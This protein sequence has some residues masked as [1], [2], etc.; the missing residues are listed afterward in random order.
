MK[1]ADAQERLLTRDNYMDVLELDKAKRL[2]RDRDRSDELYQL[3]VEFLQHS[4]TNSASKAVGP[5]ELAFRIPGTSIHVRLTNLLRDSI[6]DI[7]VCYLLVQGIVVEHPLLLSAAVLKNLLEQ[8]ARL[9]KDSGE[10]CI[11][12]SIGE[13]EP[14]TTENICSN[15]LDANCRYPTVRCRFMVRA[16]YCGLHLQATKEILT[17]LESKKVVEKMSSAEPCEWRVTV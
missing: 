15:L 11:V 7:V 1:K 5:T 16:A 4:R 3:I 12:E 10:R 13:V 2:I 9:R 17:G 6:R 14:K 8:L